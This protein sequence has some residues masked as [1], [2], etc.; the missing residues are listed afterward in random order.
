VHTG[1][2]DRVE[3][4]LE[5]RERPVAELG[6]LLAERYRTTTLVFGGA[7]EAALKAEACA[8]MRA[9][10]FAVDVPLRVSAALAG[11]WTGELLVGADR[12]TALLAGAAAA[13]APGVRAALDRRVDAGASDE[14]DVGLLGR[15]T[16]MDALRRMIARAAAAPFAVLIEGESGSGKEL[17][18]RAIHAQSG[19][20]L[21]P[22]CAVNCAALSDELLE[23][24][25]FGHVRGAFTGAARAR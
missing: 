12:V 25:L 13:C 5:L 18:A 8:R 10:A 24:E 14:R 3:V 4:A 2:Q 11:R 7:D 15:S 9:P 16:A 17:V 21:R 6:D 23:A 22:L 20:R 19:R 1:R